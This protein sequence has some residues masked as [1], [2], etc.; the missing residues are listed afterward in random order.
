MSGCLHHMASILHVLT[1]VCAFWTIFYTC[2]AWKKKSLVNQICFANTCMFHIYSISGK[3]G[4]QFRPSQVHV[5][6]NIKSVHLFES[7]HKGWH[8]RS[9]LFKWKWYVHLEIVNRTRIERKRNSASLAH[10]VLVG[11]MCCSFSF[12]VSKVQ[13][14][15]Y[16]KC[17]IYN[18]GK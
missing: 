14:N 13:F 5:H 8:F 16:Q 7:R 11:S 10:S 15:S 1:P 9:V 17:Y 18:S 4:S 3:E 6:V 2:V 12:V